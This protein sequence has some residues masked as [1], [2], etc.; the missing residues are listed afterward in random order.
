MDWCLIRS[1][2]KYV[3]STL[4]RLTEKG[5]EFDYYTMLLLIQRLASGPSNG[6]FVSSLDAEVRLMM[7]SLNMV[8]YPMSLISLTT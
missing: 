7:F 3:L 2:L 6:K 4:Y 1:N 5:T 8:D